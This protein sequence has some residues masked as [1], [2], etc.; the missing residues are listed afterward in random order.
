MTQPGKHWL[1]VTDAG[2]SASDTILVFASSQTI[3]A[4]FLA[5]TQDTVNR[6]V[7]FVNLSTPAPVSQTWFFGD[8]STSNELHPVHTFV[9]P[10]EF[11]VTLEVSNGYCSDRITKNIQVLFKTIKAE[12]PGQTQKLEMLAFS[13]YP[14]PASTE[15]MIEMAFNVHSAVQVRLMD[16]SGRILKEENVPEGLDHR[17]AVDV[18]TCANGLYLLSVHSSG[19]KGEVQKTVKF[20]KN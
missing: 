2:C 4:Q 9:L 8:G 15:L 14:N 3:E 12:L 16:L 13:V 18:S 19:L 7:Q 1:N 10:K 20:I 6:P 5:S 11:G 17:T